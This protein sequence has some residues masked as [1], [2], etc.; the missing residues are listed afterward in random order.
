MKKRV[1]KLINNERLSTNIASVPTCDDTSI[2]NCERLDLALCTV[3]SYDA[4][5]KDFYSCSA[6]K[7]DYCYYIDNEP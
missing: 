6:D 1:I 3:N 7:T 2:N 5:G 4:C